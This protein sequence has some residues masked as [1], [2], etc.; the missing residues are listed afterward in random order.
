MSDVRERLVSCFLTVFPALTPEQVAE[1]SPMTVAA[2]D[3]I[4]TLTLLT[5]LEEEFGVA[6]DFER[7]EE[8]ASFRQILSFLEGRAQ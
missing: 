1:A 4:T 2:W 3:S 5:V 6:V 8:L 7:A